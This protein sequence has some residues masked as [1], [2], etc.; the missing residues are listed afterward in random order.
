M[1]TG[2]KITRQQVEDQLRSLQD[3]VTSKVDEKKQPA[4]VAGV[5]GGFLLLLIM[6]FLGRRSGRKRSAL[7]SIR[8]V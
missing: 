1:S 2:S 8:R 3:E 7:V 4:L 5:A 6:Y